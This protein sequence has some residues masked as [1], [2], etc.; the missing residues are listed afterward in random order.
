MRAG[1][2]QLRE[3][4][5]RRNIVAPAKNVVFFLG[6]G[7]SL[8]TVTAARIYKGQKD[9]A[10]GEEA[11]LEFDNFPYFAF[12]KVRFPARGFLL[13]SDYLMELNDEDLN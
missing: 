6:D 3:Q 8:T 13:L 5:N 11:A 2:A 9:G 7:M 1:Q 4:A 10:S 12:S